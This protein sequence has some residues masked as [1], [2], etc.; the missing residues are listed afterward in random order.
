MWFSQNKEKNSGAGTVGLSKCHSL[1]H[2]HGQAWLTTN[3]DSLSFLSPFAFHLYPLALP[4]HPAVFW[5]RLHGLRLGDDHQSH[6]SFFSLPLQG[7]MCTGVLS[8]C[9]PLHCVCA[10]RPWRPEECIRSPGSEVTDNCP[11]PL[12][13]QS[14]PLNAE[15]FLQRPF[16]TLWPTVFVPGIPN[17][18]HSPFRDKVNECRLSSA[19]SPL[20]PGYVATLV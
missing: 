18:Y 3:P 8:A 16:D 10:W 6:V 2:T 11:R 14:L 4:P 1:V 15:L 5:F 12:R 20:L 13:E 9:V 17:P 7:K 19:G